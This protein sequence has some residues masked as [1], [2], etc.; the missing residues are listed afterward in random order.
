MAEM[1]FGASFNEVGINNSPSVGAQRQMTNIASKNEAKQREIKAVQ[2]TATGAASLYTTHEKATKIAEAETAKGDYIGLTSSAEYRERDAVGKKELLE[3]VYKGLPNMGKAYSDTFMGYSAG[4][5]NKQYDGAKT[6]QDTAKYNAS[7]SSHKAWTQEPSNVQDPN[8]DYSDTEAD[9]EYLTNE[10]A[11][12]DVSVFTESY[13]KDNNISRI[14]VGR[15]LMAEAYSEAILEIQSAPA[16]Q[17]GL[18]AALLNNK[19][20]MQPFESPMFMGTKEKV[21]KE[22]ITAL[23]KQR[24]TAKKAKEKEIKLASKSRIAQVEKS[25]ESDDVLGP[26]PTLVEKDIVSSTSDDLAALKQYQALE[27]KYKEQE[28]RVGFKL[29]N[30]PAFILQNCFVAVANLSVQFHNLS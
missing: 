21:G 28:I 6:I 27:K 8:Q 5:Y 22:Y 25:Y 4:E 23:E 19:D 10:Q 30:I 13:A 9:I 7:S 14:V 17:E 20:I 15:A 2:D 1:K 18:D 29:N 12:T 26:P 24:Q 3:T 11:G 16:T